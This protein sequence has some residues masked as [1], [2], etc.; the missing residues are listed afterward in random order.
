MS[1]RVISN[2]PPDKVDEVL[3]NLASEVGKENIRTTERLPNGFFR[4]EYHPKPIA[5]PTGN[6]AGK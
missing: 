5:T 4:I 6:T 2:I 1:A 3:T